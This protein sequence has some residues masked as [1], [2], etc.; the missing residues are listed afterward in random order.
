MIQ[1]NFFVVVVVLSSDFLKT[2]IKEQFA[3]QSV[4]LPARLG[5]GEAGRGA[6]EK[7]V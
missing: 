1:L 3:R 4:H 7:A 6:V 2:F 5:L